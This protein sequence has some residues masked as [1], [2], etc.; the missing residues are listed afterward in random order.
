MNI[1][2]TVPTAHVLTTAA[3]IKRLA[4]AIAVV[5]VVAS[6]GTQ[7]TLLLAHEVGGFSYAIPATIDLLAICAALAL[8]LPSLDTGSRRIAGWILTLAVGV[9]VAANVT[10]GH[11]LIARLAHAWPVIAYLL[12]E[13][14]ANRVRS[15]AARLQAADAAT[16]AV[17]QPPPAP[18]AQIPVSVPTASVLQQAQEAVRR[19]WA[20]MPAPVSPAPASPERRIT[21][22]GPVARRVAKSPLT[23]KVLMEAAP[24]V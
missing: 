20:R 12:G 14:L 2:A 7:V 8:Q 22:T 17:P 18:V 1:S 19:E 23:G 21:G 11:N 3:W 6:Y 4:M 9:S 5:G 13:L 24:R 15:Y 16:K 10:G